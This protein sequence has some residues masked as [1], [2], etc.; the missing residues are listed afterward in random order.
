MKTRGIFLLLLGVGL[1]LIDQAIKIWVKTNMYE[2]QMYE[3]F[4]WFKIYF[5]E[6]E[7][8]A[9]GITL[10]S[11]LFLSLFRL[12]AMSLLAYALYAMIKGGKYS[13][14]FLVTVTMILSGGVG[15]IIDSIFYGEVFSSSR[16]AVAEY[17]GWGNG[18]ASVFYGK[19][20]DMFY[21][22]I[23]RTTYPDWFPIY[24]GEPFVFFSP[25]FNFADACISVGVFL[26]LLFYSN[27]FSVALEEGVRAVRQ[28]FNRVKVS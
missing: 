19:V 2:T 11:K 6:N 16:H 9:Y 5:I 24:A 23:I 13:T 27:T 22:P 28:K 12:V 15:N 25:I 1:L 7:G 18:Y 10:G 8:M 17:V 4:S 3:V 20:V 14:G 21:F 26:L